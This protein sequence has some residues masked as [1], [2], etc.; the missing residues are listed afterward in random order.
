MNLL[1]H[2]DFEVRVIGTDDDDFATLV[3]DDENRGS[4]E[5]ERFGLHDA[6]RRAEKIG[7]QHESEV[8]ERNFRRYLFHCPLRTPNDEA[9]DEDPGEDDDLGGGDVG[10]LPVRDTLV[11]L[12]DAP[13]DRE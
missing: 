4:V 13:G 11:H 3:L 9:G 8:V 10:T 6:V 1:R 12:V 7:A 5:V 2:I